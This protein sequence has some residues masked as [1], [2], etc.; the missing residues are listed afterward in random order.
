MQAMNFNFLEVPLCDLTNYHA[1]AQPGGGTV[2]L[3]PQ[4]HRRQ[5]VRKHRRDEGVGTYD[6]G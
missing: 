2:A 1:G 5:T 6:A 3:H 4:G